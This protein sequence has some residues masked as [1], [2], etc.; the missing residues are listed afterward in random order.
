IEDNNRRD[1]SIGLL[2]VTYSMNICRFKPTNNTLYKLVFGQHPLCN[3]NIIEEWKQHNINIEEDL[4]KGVIEDKEVS[5][6]ENN[7]LSDGYGDFNEIIQ[8]NNTIIN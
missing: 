4:P 5:E 1:W 7:N 2:I 8:I 3:F 6:N